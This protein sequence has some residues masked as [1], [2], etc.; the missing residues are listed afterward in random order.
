MHVQR[1]SQA[2]G[3]CRALRTSGHVLLAWVRANCIGLAL[4]G[5]AYRNRTDD[6]FIT[7]AEARSNVLSKLSSAEGMNLRV[8]PGPYAAV[9]AG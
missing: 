1:S 4:L 8:R 2:L 6:L 3:L 7:S 9:R 5:A